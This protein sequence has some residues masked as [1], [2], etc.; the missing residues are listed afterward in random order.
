M[1]R[2]HKPIARHVLY[3]PREAGQGLN[4]RPSDE[5]EFNQSINPYSPLNR[6]T[7]L[8]QG[9]GHIT[10]RTYSSKTREGISMDIQDQKSKQQFL[11]DRAEVSDS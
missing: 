6:D 7:F 9:A 10:F 8:Q 5:N 4:P 11:G 1:Q 2:R 3:A